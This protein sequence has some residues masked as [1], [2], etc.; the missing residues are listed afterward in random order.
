MSAFASRSGKVASGGPEAGPT[1]R[2]S[3]AGALTLLSIIAL[4]LL[5]VG[6]FISRYPQ[7]SP[8][9]ELQHADYMIKAAHGELLRRGDRI[10]PEAAREAACRGIVDPNRVVPDCTTN[11]ERP[12]WLVEQTGVNSEEIQPPVFYVITGILARGFR[13]VLGM[14]S[15]VT[16]GRLVGGLWLAAGTTVLWTL[17]GRMQVKNV[18]RWGVTALVACSPQM[19]GVAAVINNDVTALVAGAAVLLA[20]VAWEQRALHGGFVLGVVVAAISVKPT[21][22]VGVG[23]AAGYLVIRALVADGDPRRRRTMLRMG[24]ATAGVATLAGLGFLALH[25]AIARAPAEANPNTTFFRIDHFPAEMLLPSLPNGI[26]P[27]RNPLLPDFLAT[28]P[29]R[30]VVRSGHWLL[31][32]ANLAVVATAARRT[33]EWPLA[34]SSLTA[35]AL[36]GPAYVIV[37]Y[38]ASQTFFHIPSRYALSAVPGLAVALAAAFRRPVAGAVLAGL[39]ALGSAVVLLTLARA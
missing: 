30:A 39:A 6:L 31:L 23:V 7:F 2:P 36:A 9:D 37:N 38:V 35:C 33:R 32:G 17:L 27:T 16:A 8:V 11:P 29:V 10:G 1:R 26:T 20:A 24:A 19:L 4:A 5:Q 14:S 15:I 34:V 3:P 25:G 21:N 12:P 13:A 22:V 28:G 18:T